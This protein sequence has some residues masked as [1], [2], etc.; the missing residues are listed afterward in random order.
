MLRGHEE[1]DH[2]REEEEGR[3]E[4]RRRDGVRERLRAL[5][6]E[7]IKRISHGADSEGR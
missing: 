3:G 2:G 6:R 7:E 4:G 1:G 5:S